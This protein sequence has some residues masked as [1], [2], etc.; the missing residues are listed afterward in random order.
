MN[1]IY[2][3]DEIAAAVAPVA[4]RYGIESIVLFGSYAR[5]EAAAESD[6]DLLISYEKLTGAFALGGVYAELEEALGK[7][8]DVVSENALTADYADTHAR[9]LLDEIS[10]EGVVIYRR[11]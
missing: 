8:V 7:P 9:A 3:I 6:I 2:T 4:E 1:E 10:R 11:G 5:G